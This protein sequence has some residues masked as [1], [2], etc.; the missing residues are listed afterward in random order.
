MGGDAEAFG[1]RRSKVVINLMQTH[2]DR[3]LCKI[4]TCFFSSYVFL[5]DHGPYV[6]DTP[7]KISRSK[8]PA[9]G[10]LMSLSLSN[11]VS[12][13]SISTTVG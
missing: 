1:I 11:T 4:N 3:Y 13:E 6:T 12:V 10:P 2:Y 5:K 8:L 9:H 7:G